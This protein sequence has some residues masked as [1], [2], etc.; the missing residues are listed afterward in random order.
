MQI[1]KYM[2]T[3]KSEDQQSTYEGA[4]KKRP[5]LLV[6]AD[7]TRQT[8][9]GH[10]MRALALA[11]SWQ[12][13]GGQVVFAAHCDSDA[14][15]ARIDSVSMTRVPLT[16]TYPDIADMTQTLALIDRFQPA[17]TVIDGYHFTSCYQQTIQETGCRLLVIDDMAHRAC[18]HADVILNQNIYADQ[19]IYASAGKTRLLLGSHYALLRP[20]FAAW[21]PWRR[22]VTQTAHNVLVTLGGVDSDNVTGKVVQA[23]NS[24]RGQGLS[25]KIVVGPGNPHRATLE[26]AVAQSGRDMS[27]LVAPSD[28]PA[29]MAWADTAIT[30]AGTTALELAYMQVPAIALVLADNQ[31]RVAE[32]LHDRGTLHNMGWHETVSPQALTCRLRQLLNGASMR[33]EMAHIGRQIVDGDGAKRVTEALWK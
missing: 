12:M 16:A 20:E 27:L 19:L 31:Y 18:Y 24:W 22:T 5:T 17:W 28:M 26:E 32:A 7:A 33:Q 8:G 23:L 29:L 9:S 3:L 11:Q 1:R 6:R 14:L 15:C 30:A 25:I 13:R 21:L 10:L 4:G 2:K